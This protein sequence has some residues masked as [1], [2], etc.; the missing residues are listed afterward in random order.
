MSN[1][2][3][4]RHNFGD[5]WEITF[6]PDEYV[7]VIYDN[8]RSVFTTYTR[9]ALPEDQSQ[10]LQ[11]LSDDENFAA[12]PDVWD[13]LRPIFSQKGTSTNMLSKVTSKVREIA[14]S[15]A[16]SAAVRSATKKLVKTAQK[17]VV[18]ALKKR[19]A[20]AT[21][22]AF[23]ETDEGGC[24]L[25]A[26]L[27]F[28]QKVLPRLQDNDNMNTLGDELLVQAFQFLTD[29]LADQLDPIVDIFE[30]AASSI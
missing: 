21:Y 16:S 13:R 2:N 29:R 7:V 18:A 10:I 5:G 24:V 23:L 26:I 22:T 28:S 1:K 3:L 27:G 30:A 8:D 12:S 15:G 9:G 14:V 19:K 6:D 20:P 4:P 11:F 25:A 17:T